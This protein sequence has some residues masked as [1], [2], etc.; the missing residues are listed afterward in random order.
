MGVQ[1]EA[2]DCV[3][4]EAHLWRLRRRR[5]QRFEPIVRTERVHVRQQV[6]GLCTCYVMTHWRDKLAGATLARHVL[7]GIVVGLRARAPP[8]PGAAAPPGLPPHAPVAQRIVGLCASV[9]VT[10]PRPPRHRQ[11]RTRGQTPTTG[12]GKPSPTFSVK[13]ARSASRMRVQVRVR[14]WLML[15]Q[16]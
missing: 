13:K 4:L 6:I 8:R 10:E 12:T 14:V 15:D 16:G 11:P 1:T 3:A 2:A 5:M 9:P 7:P